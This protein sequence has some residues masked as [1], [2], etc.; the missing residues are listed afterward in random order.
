MVNAL[1]R[2]AQVNAGAG[3][4]PVIVSVQH[5]P[6]RPESIIEQRA[7]HPLAGITCV[8]SGVAIVERTVKLRP[9]IEQGQQQ[10][11]QTLP[12]V[13]RVEYWSKAHCNGKPGRGTPLSSF[14]RMVAHAGTRVSNWFIT[15]A[16][17]VPVDAHSFSPPL[18]GLIP[19]SALVRSPLKGR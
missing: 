5:A 12:A 4:P 19:A 8:D 17:S 11:C 14:F 13:H 18:I 16:P 2:I 6:F 15:L 9:T 3:E 10:G 1:G 7:F